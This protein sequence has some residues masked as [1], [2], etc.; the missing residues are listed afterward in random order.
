MF[1]SSRDTCLLR[2]MAL[3]LTVSA[4]SLA[5][6]G[7]DSRG[8]AVIPPGYESLLADMLGR[9][10]E[11]PGACSFTGAS[12]D[13][14]LVR[15]RYSCASGEV[16]LELRHVD[17]APPGA[18]TTNRFALVVSEGS[19]PGELTKALEL[20]VRAREADFEWSWTP[21][22]GP[23]ERTDYFSLIRGAALV[24]L[25][26]LI[27]AIAAGWLL[28]RSMRRQAPRG[29][30]P[31]RALLAATPLA[32][33]I[34]LV[35]HA[36]LR[37]TGSSVAAIVRGDPLSGIGMR[38]LGVFG[39]ILAGSIAIALVGRLSRSGVVRLWVVAICFAYTAVGYSLSLL[40]DDLQRFGPLSTYPPDTT[41]SDTMPGQSSPV[42]YRINARGFR[43]PDFADRKRDGTIRIALIGDS[44][45]FGIGVNYDGTMRP[46]LESELARLWP[47]RSF[48]ILNLGIPGNNLA[49]HITMVEVA[50]ARLE[51]D[52]VVLGLTLSNDLSAWDE[53][54]A[55]N[56]TRRYGSYSF[57]RFLL[58][59]SV[60]SLWAMMFL[61][62]E[63]TPGGLERLETQLRRLDRI[64][65][66]SPARPM[67]V[68]FGFQPW[69]RPIAV[70]LKNVPDALMVPNRTTTA[71][72]FIPGD[73]HP[74][75]LGNRRSAAHIA[76]NLSTDPAWLSLVAE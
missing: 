12:A 42:T 31:S 2:A 26:V 43:Y 6:G 59:D 65:G 60:E 61:D 68:L 33:G 54:D 39:L 45:V 41:M 15:G 38:A 5:Y 34:C 19:A 16:V 62:R 53:Q 9:G 51:P 72:E 70:R 48:E 25:L 30:S 67:L 36:A 14:T 13:R 52:V 64:R 4:S 55:R 71:E 3:V 46:H 35:V 20:R 23:E 58:G 10:E 28:Q 37:L 40:P 69:D 11:L 75:S 63:T 32:A 66:E 50:T 17:A 21:L 76:K 18:A 8:L 29:S 7:E 1:L 49:S 73:G 27:A 74:T 24:S 44:F 22:P 57:A 56:D 47:G